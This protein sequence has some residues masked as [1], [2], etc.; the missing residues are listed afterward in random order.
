MNMKMNLVIKSKTYVLALIL[1][2]LL[3]SSIN[4]YSAAPD[5]EYDIV[6][7][8]GTIMNPETEHELKGFNLAISNGK[9]VKITDEELTGNREI[10]DRKSVV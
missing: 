9:I 1:V 5:V 8:G 10:K 4:S 6:I 7:K 3:A 2:M